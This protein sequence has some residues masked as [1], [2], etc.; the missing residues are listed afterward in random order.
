MRHLAARLAQ[1]QAE[2]RVGGE[3]APAAGLAGD[4]VEVEVGVEAEQR[5][6]EAVLPARLAVA[7][8]GVAAGPRQ[9]R[10]DV[11]LEGDRLRGVFAFLTVTA[12]VVE[13]PLTVAVIVAAP[14]PSGETMPLGLTRATAGALLE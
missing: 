4:G 10:L 6:L 13:A 5:E 7:R 2:R 12:I 11:A 3:D 14:S 1:E 8:P 9:D